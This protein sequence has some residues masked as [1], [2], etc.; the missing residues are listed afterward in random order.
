MK[1][2][3]M[4]FAIIILI[5]CVI[6]GIYLNYK[7]NYVVSKKANLKFENYLNQD[8]YGTELATVINRAIDNNKKNEVQI[9]NK[10]IYLNNDENSISIEIKMIDDDSI[11][12]MET[13]YNGGI[14]NFVNYY[15][16]IK[17][18]CMDIK[19]HNL[20]NKVKYLLFEQIT[21]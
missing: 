13:F 3:A 4:F 6:F 16:N 7:A 12:Q 11:Y 14:Q 15:G 19:Y 18:R 21:E 1:K 10:G 5:I 2:L 20:T 9:N 8:I 17:F